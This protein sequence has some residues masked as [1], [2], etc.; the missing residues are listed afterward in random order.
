MSSCLIRKL[1]FHG[2]SDSPPL[3][4]PLVIATFDG[5]FIRTFPEDSSIYILE[6]EV[7][8]IQIGVNDFDRLPRTSGSAQS[9]A[10]DVLRGCS[11]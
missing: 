1:L 6:M 11:L 3:E 4:P 9:Q 7:K 10:C 5:K 2:E 8:Y